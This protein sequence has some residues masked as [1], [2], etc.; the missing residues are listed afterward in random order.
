MVAV[1]H[2]AG[3]TAAVAGRGA[4]CVLDEFGAHVVGDLPARELAGAEVDARREI[5]VR[6][7]CDREV[8]DI[9]DVPA[10]RLP[11]REVPA[12]Q[13]GEL[14]PGLVRDR[15][16]HPA[17]QPDPHQLVLT[18]HAGDALVIH[19]LGGGGDAVVEVGGDPGC[20]V[21]AVAALGGVLQHPDPCGEGCIFGRSRRPSRSRREP[22]VERRP[23]DLDDL[24]Q[25]LHA[26]GVLVV[27][28]ELEAVHQFVSPA[29]YFA[30]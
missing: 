13:V 21:G 28:D 22:G 12:D 27:L 25:P 10:V 16:L 4:E 6:P 9:A 23:R 8:G 26:V 18:H 19:P 20:P 24:A 2:G 30:A 11:D 29:K 17:S 5:Q 15:G 14:P 1:K 3:E 7:V